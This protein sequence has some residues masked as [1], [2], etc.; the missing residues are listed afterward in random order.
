MIGMSTL[1]VYRRLRLHPGWLSLAFCLCCMTL[2][3]GEQNVEESVTERQT[4]EEGRNL[5]SVPS[6]FELQLALADP[7][8]RNPVAISWDGNARMYVIEMRGFLEED[9]SQTSRVSLHEDTDGDGWYDVH[10][11]FLDQLAEPCAILPIGQGVL[12]GDPPNI[13]YCED[14]DGDGKADSREVVTS[15]FSRNTVDVTAMPNSFLWG[16]DNRIEVSRHDRRYRFKDGILSGESVVP[17]GHW[18]LTRNDEGQLFF[19]S[20]EA[21]CVS[22]YLS[23]CSA[24]L[25]PATADS[26]IVGNPVKAKARFGEVWPGVSG[27]NGNPKSKP[28]S[29]PCGLCL[30]RGDRLGDARGDLFICDPVHGIV[31]RARI[32]RLDTGQLELTNV[33]EESKGE[34]LRSPDSNFRPVNAQTGPDGCLYVVDMYRGN[35]GEDKPPMEESEEANLSHGRIY[36]VIRSGLDRGVPPRL[37]D[38]SSQELVASLN[39][40]NG[41][42]RDMAQNLLV[43]RGD[44]KAASELEVAVQWENP[45]ARLHALWALHGLGVIKLD[46]VRRSLF[47]KDPR[48]RRGA[49]RMAEKFLTSNESPS[50]LDELISLADDPDP[51][52]IT[53]LILSLGYSDDPKA[54]R[55]IREILGEN[56]KRRNVIASMVSMRGKRT[57]DLFAILDTIER[58]GKSVPANRAA[59]YRRLAAQGLLSSFS[60]E[61]IEGFFSV[62]DQLEPKQGEELLKLLKKNLLPGSPGEPNRPLELLSKPTFLEGQP[63]A[64]QKILDQVSFRFTWPG[65]DTFGREF[66]TRREPLTGQEN[67]RYERGEL[68]YTNTCSTCHGKHGRWEDERTGELRVIPPH[69]V[70]SPILEGDRDSAIK[71]LLHGIWDG[72][73]EES[74][75][76]PHEWSG[77]TDEWFASILTYIRAAWGNSGSTITPEDVVRIRNEHT[78]RSEPWSRSELIQ[79]PSQS[80]LE[81]SE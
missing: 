45:L 11:V 38:A 7:I 78:D 44:K 1:S 48:V 71:A 74:S 10:S 33:Y 9:D 51:S 65:K 58:K 8:I 75:P 46:H 20:S 23:R 53:Q 36:R 34:F 52:V 35:I 5:I 60:G 24:S 2:L 62:I 72:S 57:K 39:Y 55:A 67:A 59:N 47:D 29:S 22:L 37:L 77:Q 17:L 32:N 16:I 19:S 14:T 25:N 56:L 4:P 28:F 73:G 70:E 27:K 42:R 31:R 54:G 40:P 13:W 50:L 3:L 26:R 21:P 49:I 61:S 68:I 15:E 41:W 63:E 18:G 69:L 12:I 79:T 66:I 6:G 80:D 64:Y 43:T 81:P 30:F 76:F